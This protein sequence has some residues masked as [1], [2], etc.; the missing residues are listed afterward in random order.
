V[1]TAPRDGLLRGFRRAR[2]A[3]DATVL[4]PTHHV[5]RSCGGGRSNRAA[6][7]PIRACARPESRLVNACMP[8]LQFISLT[9]FV[10]DR[11][12]AAGG[13]SL[14]ADGADAREGRGRV[15]GLPRGDLP[16]RGERAAAALVEAGHGERRPSL[17][18]AA[19]ATLP[20]RQ[21]LWG[22]GILCRTGDA[23]RHMEFVDCRRHG[24]R[25]GPLQVSV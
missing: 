22:G 16:E 1:A 13:G 2:A 11:L 19:V 17:Y 25:H 6:I 9:H 24:H 21:L 23:L 8:C 3:A 18:G 10:L 7:P 20:A 14:A 15:R 12:R 4:A 5:G